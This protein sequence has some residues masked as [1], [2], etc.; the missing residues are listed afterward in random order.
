M[1]ISVSIVRIKTICLGM[2]LVASVQGSLYIG[3]EVRHRVV[4][5]G[6]STKVSADPPS[7]LRH[8]TFSQFGFIEMRHLKS[9]GLGCKERSYYKTERK[10]HGESTVAVA[11]SLIYLS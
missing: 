9:D 3:R 8:K 5:I 2:M 4:G 10:S 1:G 6:T 7:V 11:I